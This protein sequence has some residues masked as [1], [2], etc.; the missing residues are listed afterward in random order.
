MKKHT[1]T[2]CEPDG[3]PM[4]DNRLEQLAVLNGIPLEE[5]FTDSTVLLL[6][7][8]GLCTVKE[9]ERNK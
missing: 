9:V 4:G 6:I 5:V 1:F 2:V 3:S 7:S 8:K